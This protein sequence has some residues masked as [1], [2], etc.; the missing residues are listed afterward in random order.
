L[1]Q[2]ASRG[3]GLEFVRQ[4]VV[5]HDRV[6]ATCRRPADAYAL[7]VLAASNPRIAILSLDATDEASIARATEEAAGLTTHLDL[8]INVTGMLHA[9]GHEPERRLA[10]VGAAGLT[11]SFAVNAIGPIVLARY[12]EP[13]LAKSERAVF[14]A[15]SARVGS[16]AD[17]RL[18]G[19]Y[20]Y[21]A[22]KA[23]LNMLIKTL[24]IEWARRKPPITCLALHPGTVDT[25]LSRP[26]LRDGARHRFSAE[27]AVRQL[28]AILATATPEQTGAFLAWN[29]ESIPW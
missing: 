27:L 21:R 4:L 14:A 11:R 29:G 23:A 1:V 20:S 6:I 9:P 24:A 2:G 3:L 10:E 5:T 25:D 16:I 26:F 28:L 15:I 19:W 7:A 18:G 8:V 17:N 13:L 22:S 12:L